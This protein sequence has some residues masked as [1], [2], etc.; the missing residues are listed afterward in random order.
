MLK[1]KRSDKSILEDGFNVP[2]TV[3]HEKCFDGGATLRM[4]RMSGW[5][6]EAKQ[7]SNGINV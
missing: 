2:F 3:L 6:D 5:L 4:R 1:W 7:C